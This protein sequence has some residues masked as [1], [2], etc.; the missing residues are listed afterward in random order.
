MSNESAIPI[1]Y[2]VAAFL[3]INYRNFFVLFLITCVKNYE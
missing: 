2:I 1:S 3:N